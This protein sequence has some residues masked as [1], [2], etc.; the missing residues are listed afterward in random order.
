MRYAVRIGVALGAAC[1]NPASNTTVLQEAFLSRVTSPVPN[2]I[3]EWGTPTESV[4]VLGKIASIR[5]RLLL[6]FF[7]LDREWVVLYLF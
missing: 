5:F 4:I 2:R 1:G 7:R 6:F 3:R